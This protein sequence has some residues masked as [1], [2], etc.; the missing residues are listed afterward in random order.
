MQE[1]KLQQIQ[2]LFQR[3]T[4]QLPIV[5][6]SSIICLH[7]QGFNTTYISQS[8]SCNIKTVYH[9]LSHYR[10][11][12]NVNNNLN[13]GRPFKI[14]K[15]NQEKIIEF[16]EEKVFT[17][18]KEIKRT[19]NIKNVSARTI[20]RTLNNHGLFGR[21]ALKEYNFSR[22]HLKKRISFGDGY[23]H[24]MNEWN[25]VLFV[26]EK[27]F[28]LGNNG[29]VWVQRP[30]KEQYNPKYIATKEAHPEKVHMWACIAVNGVGE[31]EMFEENLD[32][33]LLK[34]ILNRHLLSSALS[35]FGDNSWWYFADND[36]KH[37][38]KIVKNWLFT[39][40][41][42]CIDV[43]PYAGDLNCIENIWNDLARRVE[44]HNATTKQQMIENIKYEWNNTSALLL[45]KIVN[46]MS[47]RCLDVV[48]Q[49]G[50][51]TKY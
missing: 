32:S 47:K 45:S 48:K 50:H 35:L 25:A 34:Q 26:D 24:W 10:K 39:H 49:Q 12:R 16:A 1:K 31:Y 43:P 9:W 40:G 30:K 15:I 21:V 7:L 18:P 20:R 3:N 27:T 36:P 37:T 17:T 13:P 23:K 28:M 5:Q 22:T 2:P 19:L 8:L 51:I 41:I 33:V 14:Q 6:R 4:K 46:S 11:H 29:Q 44:S 38:S 42:Q